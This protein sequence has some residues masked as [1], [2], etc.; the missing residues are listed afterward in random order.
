MPCV[1]ENI[2]KSNDFPGFSYDGLII[3]TFFVMYVPVNL[4]K[5]HEN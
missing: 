2:S 5:T 1:L 3:P 4:I